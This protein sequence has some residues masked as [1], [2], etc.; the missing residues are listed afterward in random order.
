MC[1]V[2]YPGAPS[3]L[4]SARR[5]QTPAHIAAASGAVTVPADPAADGEDGIRGA[6]GC[7]AH[8]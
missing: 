4:Q 8:R 6:G 7:V 2:G 3:R 5:V 1:G